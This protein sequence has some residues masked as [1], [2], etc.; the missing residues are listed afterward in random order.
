VTTPYPE[1]DPTP[2]YRRG[3][4]RGDFR[5]MPDLLRPPGATSAVRP[6]PRPAGLAHDDRLLARLASRGHTGEEFKFFHEGLV[7]LGY[8]TCRRVI[9]DG[10]LATL[11]RAHGRP[12]GDLPVDV[13][14]ADVAKLAEDT[15][16]EAASIFRRVILVEG[17]WH[18]DLGVHLI[19]L[20]F[21]ACLHAYPAQY[22]AW[23]RRTIP[24]PPAPPGPTEAGLPELPPPS[25]PDVDPEGPR[26]AP[27]ALDERDSVRI[28]FT[29]WGYPPDAILA[30]LGSDAASIA[31][32]RDA[33]RDTDLATATATA[34]VTLTE[35]LAPLRLAPEPL[36]LE[37][38]VAER[39]I[40][41]GIN[42]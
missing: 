40:I 23:F 30:V 8:A 39:D 3:L 25:P 38:L 14:P 35:Q 37:N 29:R 16:V 36:A 41:G 19:D 13:D 18:V 5:R 11:C 21:A 17:Q 32:L 9:G 33:G 42:D 1:L 15:A 6:A 4:A 2:M 22:R 10:R 7:Q 12:V 28:A 24:P 34:T 27:D 26:S 31:R 20:Y